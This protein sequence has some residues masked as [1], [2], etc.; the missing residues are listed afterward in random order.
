MS[1]TL[2]G[3]HQNCLP[4]QQVINGVTEMASEYNI[5]VEKYNDC[6][7]KYN[8]VAN[9]Y[10]ELLEYCKQLNEEHSKCGKVGLW[11][12]LKFKNTR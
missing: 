10:N 11:K 8:N 1:L 3:C 4:K 9:G 5:C 2:M 6:A 7:D 12:A